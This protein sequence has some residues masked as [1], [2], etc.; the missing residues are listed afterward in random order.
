MFL[1][2]L[3]FFLGTHNAVATGPAYTGLAAAVDS[4]STE[5]EDILTG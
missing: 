1:V 2:S 3:M 5:Y 4:A